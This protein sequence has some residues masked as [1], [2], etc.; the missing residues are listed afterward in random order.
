MTGWNVPVA[1]SHQKNQNNKSKMTEWTGERNLGSY[2]IDVIKAFPE[3]L[4]FAAASILS[5]N[6]NTP[7]NCLKVLSGVKYLRW[8]TKRWLPITTVT[9]IPHLAALPLLKVG[10]FADSALASFNL[11]MSSSVRLSWSVVNISSFV[12]I[13][14][15]MT[16]F[17][18]IL[19]FTII[20]M[21][22]VMVI[23]MLLSSLVRLS[24]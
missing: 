9:T 6:S 4:G 10:L 12:I 2:D 19:S 1:S 21:T 5:D 15:I 3:L 23:M 7:S 8:I 22:I 24:W 16:M 13:V 17:I 18:M 14:M 11:W 20:M